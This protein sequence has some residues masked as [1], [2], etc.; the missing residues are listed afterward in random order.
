MKLK[1]EFLEFIKIQRDFRYIKSNKSWYKIP[2][3]I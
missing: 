1:I 2:T 3:F